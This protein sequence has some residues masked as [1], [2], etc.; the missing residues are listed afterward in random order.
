MQFYINGRFL[1]QRVTGVQ[2]YARELVNGLDQLL[3]EGDLNPDQTQIEVLVPP[4]IEAE[5][6][7]YQQI[8]LRTVGTKQGHVWEQWDLPRATG[9]QMLLNLGNTAP[10]FKKNQLVTIHDVSVYTVPEAYSPAFRAWYKLQF[11]QLSRSLPRIITVSEF[12]KREMVRFLN[13]PAAKIQVTYEGREHIEAIAPDFSV[14]DRPE[15]KNKS[16]VL[17]VSSLSP[18]KNFGAV[19]RALEF[20]KDLPELSVVIIG[21]GNQQV[22]AEMNLEDNPQVIRP[23]YVTDA[24]LKA[25]YQNALGFI[26]ASLYEGFGL[27][28]LEAMTCGC[29]VIVSQAAA[30]PEVCGNAALYF[31]PTQPE[32][33]A[34]Q[35]RRLV[36]DKSLREQLKEKAI[37]Q[38]AQFSWKKCA[39]ETLDVI[40]SIDLG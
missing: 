32:A 37:A 30:I 24:Q 38:S 15:L 40:Q 23:G 12:S 19:V 36:M 21:G 29:P 1:S 10:L 16:Y 34:A 20:L 26:H 6:P 18:H 27:T 39:L 9:K 13:T 28:P 31:D 22:F 33:I 5:Q 4:G 7:D 11:K 8:G 25:L 3:I 17:A 2:R 35:V 14:L